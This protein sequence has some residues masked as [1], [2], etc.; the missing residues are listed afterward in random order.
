[1]LIAHGGHWLVNVTYTLPVIGLLLF[2][3]R[4]KLKERREDRGRE[5]QR[6]DSD[7]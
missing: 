2:V 6:Q 3:G 4:A 1:M 7:R 5:R